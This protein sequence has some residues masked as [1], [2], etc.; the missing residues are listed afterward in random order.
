MGTVFTE[1]I[2]RA[3]VLR[4]TPT[5]QGF[6]AAVLNALTE[7]TND[8]EAACRAVVWGLSDSG[9]IQLPS[10]DR[11]LEALANRVGA[12]GSWPMAHFANIDAALAAVAAP[13]L[14][15]NHATRARAREAFRMAAEAVGPVAEVVG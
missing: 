8:P 4:H 1:R 11:W 10:M 2:N 15:G 3:L 13:P 7:A 12:D 6:V 14:D 9:G 5:G